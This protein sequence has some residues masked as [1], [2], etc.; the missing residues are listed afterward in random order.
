MGESLGLIDL[1]RAAKISGSRFAVFKGA[2]AQLLR[3]LIQF[4]LD[5]QT[6]ENGYLELYPPFLVNEESLLGTGQLPKFAEDLF[7]MKD[8]P[9][10]LIPTA[11]VPV[12]NYHRDEV[13]AREDL[14]LKYAAYTPCFRREAGF[15][16][17]GHTGID[18]AAP[19]R[20]G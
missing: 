6:R 8:D 12:T 20:Q 18:P 9:Y 5:V 14:P 2:G 10:Y 17:Q 19:V 16:W 1:K 13:L 15:L 4:M 7:R 11:E 3:G